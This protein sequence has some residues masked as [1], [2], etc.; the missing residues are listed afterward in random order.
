MPQFARRGARVAYDG[1]LG[2]PRRGTTVGARR[3]CLK[4]L[5]DGDTKPGLYHPKWAIRFL[6][7]IPPEVPRG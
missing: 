1:A 3:Q 6:D 5:T 4:I 2:A 7:L